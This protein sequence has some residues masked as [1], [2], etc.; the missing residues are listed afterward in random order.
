VLYLALT[1]PDALRVI[2]RFEHVVVRL[3]LTE[4]MTDR[5]RVGVAWKGSI[6]PGRFRQIANPSFLRALRK[7]PLAKRLTVLGITILI[8]RHFAAP[9]GANSH[10]PAGGL[11][12]ALPQIRRLL[13]K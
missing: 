6:G 8:L 1:K 2:Y 7:Q 5:F 4:M 3:P 10:F 9:S 12:I 13:V 11:I